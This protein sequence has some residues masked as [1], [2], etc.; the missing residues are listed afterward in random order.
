LKHI[1]VT[2]ASGF[3]G[4]ALVPYLA[5]RGFAVRAAS[6]R[7]FPAGEGIE[8]VPSPDLAGSPDW[9]PLL[10]GVDV[11]VHTAAIAHTRGVDAA[12]QDAVNHR[13]VTALAEA[14]R[15]RVER[16][17]FLSSIRA[18]SAS[19]A[20][21][22]L[23]EAQEPRPADAYGRAKLAAE[24]ALARTGVPFVILRPVLVA[25]SAPSG[26]LGALLRLARVGLPL[27]MGAFTAKR[28]LVDRGD[29]CAAIVHV[30]FERAHL[31]ATYIVAHP[32]PIEIAAM[33]AALRQ[34]LNRDAGLFAVP[35]FLTH[36]ALA[37]PFMGEM[38]A[39]LLGDLVASPEKLMKTG[40]EPKVT[41]RLAL[42]RLGAASLDLG[43]A[44]Q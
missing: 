41:P 29:L 21:R 7:P 15:G 11:I 39:K 44:D 20:A 40:W 14:A 24:E 23:T 12:M 31:G 13:A 4:R 16:L 34:G 38:R 43:G 19:C 30:L 37:F 32:E 42:A 18:Q 36:M 8:A 3:I 10:E 35:S 28:S 27:P 2:G 17:I 25:G 1:L 6:R 26:N 5:E 9:A 33:L 22:T